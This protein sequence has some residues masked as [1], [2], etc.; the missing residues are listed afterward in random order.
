[1]KKKWDIKWKIREDKLMSNCKL[2]LSMTNRTTEFLSIFLFKKDE[3][4]SQS[5]QHPWEYKLDKSLD[6]R[7][8]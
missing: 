6:K 3:I 2:S 4:F 8:G 5:Y 7:L 1:M